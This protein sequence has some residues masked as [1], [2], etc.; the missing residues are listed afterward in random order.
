M[1]STD[2][3][4]DCGNLQVNFYLNDGSKT[5]LDPLIFKDDRA[6]GLPFKF[7]T[8]QTFDQNHIGDYD[9]SY[10]IFYEDYTTNS[11]DNSESFLIQILP[12]CPVADSFS[13][14]AP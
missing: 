12:A 3:W 4:V 11:I 13:A 2:A 9:I 10:T 6:G 14:S 5:P 7:T 8:L 1:V